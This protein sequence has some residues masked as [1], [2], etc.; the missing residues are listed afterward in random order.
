[1]NPYEAERKISRR[2]LKQRFQT[3]CPHLKW[4]FFSGSHP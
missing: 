1:M 3:A 2:S 4:R